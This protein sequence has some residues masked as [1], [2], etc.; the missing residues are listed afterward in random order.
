MTSQ[1]LYLLISEEEINKRVTDAVRN[2]WYVQV[3]QSHGLNIKENTF[4]RQTLW[5]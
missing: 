2:I 3:G 1:E 5:L 4:H